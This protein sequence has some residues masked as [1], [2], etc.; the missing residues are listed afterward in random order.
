MAIVRTIVEAEVEILDGNGEA[1]IIKEEVMREKRQFYLLH[2][3]LVAQI[4]QAEGGEVYPANYT[5]G[6]CQDKK[7]G[8]IKTFL[9]EELRVIGIET[10]PK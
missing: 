8:W 4:H 5:V 6:I 9:P 3:G 2:W 1:V 7:T 10:K